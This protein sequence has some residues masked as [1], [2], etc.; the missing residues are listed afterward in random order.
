[1]EKTSGRSAQFPTH[2]R[3]GSIT[4][5]FQVTRDVYWSP[6]DGYG[7]ER[8]HECL[9][10]MPAD[11]VA[12]IAWFD[13]DGDYDKL[14][15]AADT[16]AK[17]LEAMGRTL[18]WLMSNADECETDKVATLREDQDFAEDCEVEKETALRRSAGV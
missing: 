4:D 5:A 3:V 14:L 8:D 6:A 12:K 16:N 11:D 2:Y 1:M 17:L 15:S 18:I 7:I 9:T 13:K 10:N